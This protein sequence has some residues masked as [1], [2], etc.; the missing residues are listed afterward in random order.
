[1]EHKS[2]RVLEILKIKDNRITTLEKVPSFVF[3]LWDPLLGV[4]FLILSLPLLQELAAT[5]SA[6]RGTDARLFEANEEAAASR[7]RVI[8][9]EA[10][11]VEMMMSVEKKA[12]LVDNL[13]QRLSTSSQEAEE[14]AAG[15]AA[16]ILDLSRLQAAMRLKDRKHGAAFSHRDHAETASEV[17]QKLLARDKEVHTLKGRVGRQEEQIDTLLEEIEQLRKDSY[18][19][20]PMDKYLLPTLD[21]ADTS[22]TAEAAWDREKVAYEGEIA[23]L[24]EKLEAAAG[25][26][27]EASIHAPSK[28]DSSGRQAL[29]SEL[30]V[31]R[32]E[33][34]A[35]E[36]RGELAVSEQ[37]AAIIEAKYEMAGLAKTAEEARQLAATRAKALQ[38]AKANIDELKIQIKKLERVKEASRE[39]VS[40]SDKAFEVSAERLADADLE[41]ARELTQQKK[42]V[43][44]LNA[45]VSALRISESQQSATI[46]D[47]EEQLSQSRREAREAL[48]QREG[49]EAKAGGKRDP[50]P[51]RIVVLEEGDVAEAA[52]AKA[53][54]AEQRELDR[55]LDMVESHSKDMGRLKASLQDQ[56]VAMVTLEHKLAATTSNHTRAEQTSKEEKSR[57]EREVVVLTQ[58]LRCQKDDGVIKLGALEETV[59]KLSSRGEFQTQISMLH[60]ELTSLQMSEARAV[61]SLRDLETELSQ[62]KEASSEAG[63]RALRAELSL[64][65]LEL[66]GGEGIVDR[67]ALVATLALKCDQQ[68]AELS[69]RKHLVEGGRGIGG[70]SVG[71]TTEVERKRAMLAMKE[72]ELELEFMKREV[73]RLE[74]ERA[75]LEGDHARE[76]MELNASTSAHSTE[77]LGRIAGLNQEIEAVRGVKETLQAELAA[78]LEDKRQ[79]QSDLE[80][81]RK[82]ETDSGRNYDEK[83]SKAMAE[84]DGLRIS[85]QKAEA[86]LAGQKT[87]YQ[88]LA[89]T[90]EAVK[91]KEGDVQ[92]QVIGLA[93]ELTSSAEREA[94]AE[95]RLLELKLDIAGLLDEAKRSKGS[96]LAQDAENARLKARCDA[97]TAQAEMCKGE[98]GALAGEVKKLE[99]TRRKLNYQL[100]D[101]HRSLVEAQAELARKHGNVVDP[102][103]GGALAITAGMEEQGEHLSPVSPSVD[104]GSVTA[105]PTWMPL[106][107]KVRLSRDQLGV[108][109]IALAEVAKSTA[110]EE[111]G[112]DEIPLNVAEICRKIHELVHADDLT[113]YNEVRSKV[114]AEDEAQRLAMSLTTM[115]R[116]AETAEDACSAAAIRDATRITE[117]CWRKD[118]REIEITRLENRV[119]V[120]THH[121]TRMGEGAVKLEA[122]LKGMEE[123]LSVSRASAER[124]ARLREVAEAKVTMLEPRQEAL[125]T[126]EGTACGISA[127]CCEAAAEGFAKKIGGMMKSSEGA[128]T[129]VMLARAAAALKI[130]EARLQEQVKQL[131]QR[132]DAAHRYV[133]SLT[134]LTREMDGK[135]HRAERASQGHVG[136]TPGPTAGDVRSHALEARL[137]HLETQ[138]LKAQA[139]AGA[140]EAKLHES[141]T[142]S[143]TEDTRANRTTQRRYEELLQSK[144]VM[145]QARANEVHEARAVAIAARDAAAETST[146]LQRVSSLLDHLTLSQAQ[147]AAAKQAAEAEVEANKQLEE[148]QETIRTVRNE[149]SRVRAKLARAEKAEKAAVRE[150]EVTAQV[151]GDLEKT[152]AMASVKAKDR[153]TAAGPGEKAL[154]LSKQLIAAKVAEADTIRRLRVASRSEVELRGK[155]AERD[156]RI[157]ELKDAMTKAKPRSK[158]KQ[159]SAPKSSKE[160]LSQLVADQR[161]E[162]DGLR[163]DLAKEIASKED[164]DV[165]GLY[166]RLADAK[167]K[168]KE[169]KKAI[170]K[171]EN[172]LQTTHQAHEASLE[173]GTRTNELLID[174]VR[175]LS[176]QLHSPRRTE[177]PEGWEGTSSKAASTSSGRSGNADLAEHVL[178]GFTTRIAQLEESLRYERAEK[179]VLD[180]RLSLVLD[181][182]REL[183]GLTPSPASTIQG[184]TSIS[185]GA[186]SCSSSDGS[187]GD[188][189]PAPVPGC[190]P[191][192]VSAEA[193]LYKEQESQKRTEGLTIQLAQ[194]HRREVAVEELHRATVL[195]SVS[196]KEKVAQ[197][198]SETQNLQQALGQVMEERHDFKE[199]KRTLLAQVAELQVAVEAHHSSPQGDIDDSNKRKSM[200]E[201]V[202]NKE[203][204]MDSAQSVPSHNASQT[205]S[206]LHE[207]STTLSNRVATS[208]AG[209]EELQKE[210]LVLK[211]SFRQMQDTLTML[212]A[213][214]LAENVREAESRVG[215]LEEACGELWAVSGAIAASSPNA[216]DMMQTETDLAKCRSLLAVAEAARDTAEVA[217]EK[218]KERRQ[219]EAERA[220]LFEERERRARD[221]GD[222]ARSMADE[223]R[224]ELAQLRMEKKED[225]NNATLEHLPSTEGEAT[226]LKAQLE[227]ARKSLGEVGA[228]L[229]AATTSHLPVP[230]FMQDSSTQ[231]TVNHDTDTNELTRQ[232]FA[233][234]YPVTEALRVRVPAAPRHSPSASDLTNG[235]GQ[236]PGMLQKVL[237]ELEQVSNAACEALDSKTVAHIDKIITA[238]PCSNEDDKNFRRL[239]TVKASLGLMGG[240]HGR[241]SDAKEQ[242]ATSLSRET[243]SIQ[244]QDVYHDTCKSTAPG[245]K[246]SVPASE[247]QLQVVELG[248]MRHLVQGLREAVQRDE[249]LLIGLQKELVGPDRFR[250]EMMVAPVTSK[251]PPALSELSANLRTEAAK[252]SK[253]KSKTKS[254]KG[255][256]AFSGDDF[257]RELEVHKLRQSLEAA[258]FNLK[259]HQAAQVSPTDIDGAIL[260]ELW[261]AQAEKEEASMAL[262]SLRQEMTELSKQAAHWEESAT[263]ERR[264]HV[265][266]ME[267][268][269]ETAQS[270]VTEAR[271][272]EAQAIEREGRKVSKVKRLQAERL[273][274]QQSLDLE[275]GRLR[276]LQET[277]LPPDRQDA[278]MHCQKEMMEQLKMAKEDVKRKSNLI[279]KLKTDKESEE[280]KKKTLSEQV[281]M[282]EAKLKTSIKDAS[283]K[284]SKAER[285]LRDADEREAALAMRLTATEA[286]IEQ[287]QS[288]SRSVSTSPS[289]ASNAASSRIAELSCRLSDLGEDLRQRESIITKLE[290]T[291]SQQGSQALSRAEGLSKELTEAQEEVSTWKAAS[292][293]AQRKL[294]K[295][296]TVVEAKAK[297]VSEL[298]EWCAEESKRDATEQAE[299]ASLL[300]SLALELSQST[301]ELG[302]SHGLPDPLQTAGREALQAARDGAIATQLSQ[303]ELQ[304][305][306]EAVSPSSMERGGVAAGALVGRA[307]QGTKGS[308][309]L[310][311]SEWHDALWT[312]I[313]QRA[314][315]EVQVRS[316]ELAKKE[317]TGAQKGAPNRKVVQYEKAIINYVERIRE[318]LKHAPIENKEAQG[319]CARLLKEMEGKVRTQQA[320]K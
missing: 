121:L 273:D 65:R 259:L 172:A 265:E 284:K 113:R 86:V 83:L 97:A 189:F 319:A 270:Q 264:A 33:F 71:W 69:Q 157:R 149:L 120:L 286:E 153:K 186:A 231:C 232:I 54:S 212:N 217:A 26:V 107:D 5:S 155:V 277:W 240:S 85:L 72:A 211:T 60:S 204:Q 145:E 303:D 53:A 267:A 193:Q 126:T 293:E 91:G 89:T 6:L 226:S 143:H 4:A 225:K 99:D 206:E 216:R 44:S 25:S 243:R 137:H 205:W 257:E 112:P 161:E 295:L 9:L 247:W 47:L 110:G 56:E 311:K 23:L 88:T 196:L 102:G 268:L 229:K 18:G 304:D 165:Q 14:A 118:E 192:A 24:Q 282:L 132:N 238:G 299:T 127:N 150:S 134:S 67:N 136:R 142:V 197:L 287:S 158:T 318:L 199:S 316:L 10:E 140:L 151:I 123:Q 27:M 40:R 30:L 124:E 219:A 109:L 179:A 39:E 246:V 198:S 125:M 290:A 173:E 36:L 308:P 94:E 20:D 249:S 57:L 12:K 75:G 148:D 224:R 130:S 227:E 156:L 129:A 261:R 169:L 253:T 203:A 115:R 19:G 15:Q 111:T 166:K 312:L 139:E 320:R 280:R 43:V 152:L 133:L 174:A 195:E 41:H 28:Y 170:T 31:L 90:L 135:L 222:A 187:V 184:S 183:P 35:L 175:C 8:E 116:R 185:P 105:L 106:P 80:S 298:E 276:K 171:K 98:V 48:R 103:G 248:E 95:S 237:L 220:E 210:M 207:Q 164:V 131:R 275:Q 250:L 317:E 87:S 228:V 66:S 64:S 128:D 29:E 271:E 51:A 63:E 1:M 255:K 200:G 296:E 292:G 68:A 269:E 100:E 78:A 181:E 294:E 108:G 278:S 7:S 81:V 160:E 218:E 38:N 34:A 213:D 307:L 302:S 258:S 122:A 182:N 194:A 117:E 262:D 76:L 235:G 310:T 305:V 297:R 233:V 215:T 272:R 236:E 306:L 77:S 59:K 281:S 256:T 167:T 263:A 141:L 21:G 70:G 209:K 315:V 22:S 55:E 46:A 32:D 289:A 58:K 300:R 252:V 285:E 92:H 154:Q 288:R 73:T 42:F 163:L 314:E 50:R 214:E 49:E 138:L 180:E 159:T 251:A 62:H 101:A 11:R 52:V 239:E 176:E 244:H 208:I 177:H 74:Q 178:A 147:E 2:A 266:Q 223:L 190:S 241:L 291:V 93:F 260:G 119:D 168:E 279:E 144:Q 313:M 245:I 202:T 309:E 13:Q 82:S 96:T 188:T 16:S 146:E 191:G 37:Q 3:S 79:I 274:L 162:I 114:R 221:R 201:L 61:R 45:K 242:L 283:R 301:E 234:V 84:A 104:R 17:Q 254:K 230:P